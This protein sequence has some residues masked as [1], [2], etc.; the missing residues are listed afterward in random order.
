MDCLIHEVDLPIPLKKQGRNLYEINKV[1]NEP[2]AYPLRKPDEVVWGFEEQQLCRFTDRQTVICRLLAT[3][4]L[5][6]EGRTACKYGW[7]HA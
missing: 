7:I 2:C 3:C 4:N 5:V 1:V 6:P